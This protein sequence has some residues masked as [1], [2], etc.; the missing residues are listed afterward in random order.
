MIGRRSNPEVRKVPMFDAVATG[1][2]RLGALA[3]AALGLAFVPSAAPQPRDT[4][5]LVGRAS[6]GGA[7]VADWMR[8]EET[9]VYLE[10]EEVPRDPSRL[11]S[12]AAHPVLAQKD[13]RYIPHVVVMMAGT[14]LRITNGDTILHNVHTRSKGRRKNPPFNEGQEPGEILTPRFPAPDSIL[15]LCDIH[16]QMQAHLFVLPHP[17]FTLADEDGRFEIDGVPPGRYLMTAWNEHFGFRSFEVDI[18]GADTTV[19]SVTFA[20]DEGA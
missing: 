8:L 7:A 5:T 20:P 6:F 11:D 17:F 2:A 3:C 16:S 4:G 9:V 12:A 13:Q 10:G 15:V 14:E 18:P 19:V 1:P